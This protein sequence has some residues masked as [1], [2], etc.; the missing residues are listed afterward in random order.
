MKRACVLYSDQCL[1]HG[2]E[3]HIE[4]ARRL[5]A[6]MGGLNSS[7]LMGHVDVV[8]LGRAAERQLTRVHDLDYVRHIETSGTGMLD[9]DT[10]MT[11]GSLDAARLAAGAALD[12]VEEVRKGRELA[13]GLVRPPGH[14]ALPGRAMGFCIFNNAAIGAA[15]AL[16][17]YRKVLV[18]DW[19]V[20]HG[21]GTQQIFYRT[22]DVLYFSVH[23]SP[24][25]PYT[26]DAAETGEGEGEGF[27][28]NVPLPAGSTDADFLEAF[29]RVLTPI[30]DDYKPGLVIVSAGYDPAQGD[31]LGDM[32]MTPRGFQKLAYMVRTMSSA[33]GVVAMLEGGYSALLPDCVAA[34]IRGFLGEDA[35]IEPETTAGAVSH[36]GEAVRIQRQYWRI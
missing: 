31:P 15:R 1:L 3:S 9:P 11:A 20:H 27:N 17:H 18:V 19:D 8:S 26:G 36:I 13:F 12:A 30:T 34:S 28:V 32:R 10:E 23:Q 24:H 2:T 21:N 29:L 33:L 22:P 25:F 14:H 16:D 7:E 35:E 6:I 4:N 5:T